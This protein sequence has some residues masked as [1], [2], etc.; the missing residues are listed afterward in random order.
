MR[1]PCTL[2]ATIFA[3]S[4]SQTAL[5]QLEAQTQASPTTIAE[6][7][8][9]ETIALPGP[10]TFSLSG[11]GEYTFDGKLR[12]AGGSVNIARAGAEAIIGYRLCPDWQI[13]LKVSPEHS[14]YRWSEGDSFGANT[15]NA[16][17][18]SIDPTLRWR[19]DDQWSAI[20]GGLFNLSAEDGGDVS[21]AWRAGGILGV[22]YA[23][24]KTFALTGG[25]IASS[26][27]EETPFV[28]P[29][30]GLE[31]SINDRVRVLVRG[32]GAQIDV[33]LTDD[34]TASLYGEYQVREYRLESRGPIQDPI[35]RDRRIPVGVKLAYAITPSID[36][37]ASGGA[38]VYQYYRFDDQN[39]TELA[40]DRTRPTG[41]VGGSITFRF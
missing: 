33:D 22:R 17:T 6:R 19:I 41:F 29:L 3:A 32:L 23:F 24:S 26:R 13:S 5:A 31:W 20:I 7:T 4:L 12:D 8:A 36:L 15:L 9:N 25:I 37:E 40:N 38:I 14:W 30:I 39:G 28:V 18:V 1:Y 27:L 2:T 34:L 10:L 35:L 11:S 16:Y 21:N